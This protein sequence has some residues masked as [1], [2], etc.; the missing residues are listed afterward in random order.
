MG[1]LEVKDKVQRMLTGM[2]GTLEIDPD[3]D[4]TFPY[5]ST[6]VWVSVLPWD[7]QELTLVRVL[8]I[9]LWFIPGSPALFERVAIDANLMRFGA[10]G[11]HKHEEAGTY[12]LNF[13]HTLIGET[14]DPEELG[15]A[16]GAVATTADQLDDEYLAAFGGKRWVDLG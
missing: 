5:E 1:V 15:H 3:G 14:L 13:S 8:S 4:F 2:V 7:G 11:L 10:L 6:R 16:V 9:P 12:N